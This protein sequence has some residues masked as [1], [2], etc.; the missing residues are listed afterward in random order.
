[1][2]PTASVTVYSGQIRRLNNRIWY[3]VQSACKAL[4]KLARGVTTN[5]IDISLQP[6]GTYLELQAADS[7]QRPCHVDV[8]STGLRHY[9]LTDLHAV[10]KHPCFIIL[11]Q[12]Y[13]HVSWIMVLC[14]T[15]N[16]YE[17]PFD[18][19]PASEYK[20]ELFK[21]TRHDNDVYTGNLHSA[22]STFTTRR[23]HV[24][25]TWCI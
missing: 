24:N 15:E 21:V 7:H 4:A 22:V 16:S 12:I 3:T 1:M 25:I 10:D 5:Y 2:A 20:L 23:F 19:N 17:I 6:H 9:M 11:Q 14:G 18:L 8:I 13:P